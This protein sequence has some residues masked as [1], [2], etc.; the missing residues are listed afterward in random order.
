M[1]DNSFQFLKEPFKTLATIFLEVVK[2]KVKVVPFETVRTRARQ[3]WLYANKKPGQPVA[4]PGMS[5]H[6][7]GLAIDRVFTNSK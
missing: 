6:E 5:K 3:A 4:K 7:Q 2:T 1:I